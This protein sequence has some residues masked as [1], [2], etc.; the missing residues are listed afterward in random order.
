MAGF[1][2]VTSGIR[3]CRMVEETLKERVSR[4][5]EIVRDWSDDDGIASMWAAYVSNELD[6]QRDLAESQAKHVEEKI[7]DRK[8]EVQSGLDELRQI[9]QSLHVDVAVLKKVVL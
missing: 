2:G 4:L 6:V 8:T 5:E 9:I 3:A 1:V 7:V